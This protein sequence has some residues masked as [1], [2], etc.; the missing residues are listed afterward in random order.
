MEM[1]PHARQRLRPTLIAAG[2][3]IRL[4]TAMI[5]VR[6]ANRAPPTARI[7][8]PHGTIVVEIAATP[9]A[10]SAGLS[11]RNEL[12]STDG[13]LLRWDA[14]GRHP[15]WM[16]GMRFP[17]DLVWIDGAGR[18][19]AVVPNVQPCRAEPC[20]LYEPNGTATAVAVL[21]LPAGGA[22]E[23]RLGAGVRVRFPGTDQ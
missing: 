21:E 10:R 11:N 5:W 22:A 8:T 17:L 13:M 19:L 1:N 16:A 20:T 3:A 7:E 6:S 4:M 18:V 12:H 15:I 9:A 2:I 23:R 14:P